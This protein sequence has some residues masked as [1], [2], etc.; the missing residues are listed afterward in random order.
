MNRKKFLKTCGLACLGATS[1]APLL[2]NC[3]LPRQYIEGELSGNTLRVLK[4]LFT[5]DS[6][7]KPINRSYVL[8]KPENLRF[9]IY[10]HKINESEYTALWME[11]THMGAELTA[12]GDYLSCPSHG[13]EFDKFGNV[14]EGPAESMLRKF[15]Y[16]IDQHYINI[17]LS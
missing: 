16:T 17:Q 15:N 2:Q 3:T 1:I 9:P 4:T 14:T 8:V 11:C 5:E 7:G 13:S 12:H 10:L 6:K